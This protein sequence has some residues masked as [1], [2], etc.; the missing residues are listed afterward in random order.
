MRIVKTIWAKYRIEFGTTGG[1]LGAYLGDTVEQVHEAINLDKR[2]DSDPSFRN[3][4]KY[5]YF[6]E[7]TDGNYETKD[8]VIDNCIHIMWTVRER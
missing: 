3:I 2:L 1:R 5:G 6:G 7:F 8:Y 4:L